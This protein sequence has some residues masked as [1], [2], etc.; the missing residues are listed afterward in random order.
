TPRRDEVE[1]A[2]RVA[3]WN[4]ERLRHIDAITETLK[5]AAPDVTI[6]CEV[7]RGMA[8]TQNT[9]RIVDLAGR[10]DQP[11]IYA[12]EFVELGL[13]DVHEQADHAGETNAEDFHGAA[14][15]SDVTM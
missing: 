10:L 5:A 2:A 14:L 6:L 12:V 13:G 11:Y 8:R 15:L 9:D 4:V 3:F 7:D 1:G